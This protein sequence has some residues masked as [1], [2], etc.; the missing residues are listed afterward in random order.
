MD[1]GE[2]THVNRDYF[3]S[4]ADRRRP[5]G[6]QVELI[7]EAAAGGER[8]VSRLAVDAFVYDDPVMREQVEDRVREQLLREIMKKWKPEIRVRR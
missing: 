1:E 5:L 7:C 3:F 2:P 4:N 8:F 6:N